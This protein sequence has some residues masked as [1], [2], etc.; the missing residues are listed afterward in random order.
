MHII[1]PITKKDTERFVEI[2]FHAGIGMTSMPKNRPVLM[3]RVDDAV[4]AFSK[5]VNQ[6]GMENYLFVMEDLATGNIGGT[7]GITAKNGPNPLFFYRLETIQTTNNIAP[8]PQSLRI[9][10]PVHYYDYPSEIGSLYLLPDF[11]HSGLG[12]LLSLSRFLFMAAYPY[13][14]DKMV[15]AEMRGYIDKN[16]TSPFW[17][18]I[19]RHFLDMDFEAIMHMR[20]EEFLN[21]ASALPIYPI[22]IDL[23]SKEAQ[24]S[25]GKIHFNT[26]A[27]LNMLIQEGFQLSEEIDV[28]DGGPKIEAEISEIRTVRESAVDRVAEITTLDIHSPRHIVSNNTLNFRACYS[29]LGE[30]KDGLIIPAAVAEALQLQVGDDVRYVLS[31]GENPESKP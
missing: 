24:E 31:T 26:Q 8:A 15:F 9:M 11:R 18:G 2:A 12:R 14:F 28:F 4:E 5:N 23:L 10:R 21:V 7:C 6:P 25:L 1:R 19:G 17:E 20:D 13:R 30:G 3:K 22:Y 27:A 16:N 29:P